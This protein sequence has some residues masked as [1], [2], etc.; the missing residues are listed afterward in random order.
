M[1]TQIKTKNQLLEPISKS[2]L[3]EVKAETNGWI[4]R[5]ATLWKATYKAAEGSLVE[6]FSVDIVKHGRLAERII[7]GNNESEAENVY[8][9]AVRETVWV[10]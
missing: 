2:I 6:V 1:Q 10:N 9:D 5:S 4:T 7:A 3:K 8:F